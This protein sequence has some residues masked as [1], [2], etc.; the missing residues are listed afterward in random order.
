MNGLGGGDLLVLAEL[1]LAE[2]RRRA[3][4]QHLVD[5]HG[6]R[7]PGVVPGVARAVGRGLVRVGARLERIGLADEAVADSRAQLDTVP[8]S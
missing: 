4:H 6:R 8:A 2:R 5:V 7:Q 3:R 1:E